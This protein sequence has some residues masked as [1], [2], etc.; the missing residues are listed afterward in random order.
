MCAKIRL[1]LQTLLMSNGCSRRRSSTGACGKFYLKRE[2]P[3]RDVLFFFGYSDE[4]EQPIFVLANEYSMLAFLGIIVQE[5]VHL[6]DPVFSNPVAT[7]AFFQVPQAGLWQILALIGFLEVFLHRGKIS[8][9]VMF[10]DP[11]TKVCVIVHC[12]CEASEIPEA[13]VVV[14]NRGSLFL[15]FLHPAGA[16]WVQPS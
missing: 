12:C 11:E 3:R 1:D 16:S 9:V 15:Y 4:C 14:A 6:P 10:E 5:F 8:S 7:E 2:H 13:S